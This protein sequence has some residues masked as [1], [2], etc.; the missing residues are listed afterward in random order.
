MDN[1]WGPKL[2]EAVRAG[3]VAEELIDDK[4]RRVLRLAARTGALEG[5]PAPDVPLDE[6]GPAVAH[7]V[8]VR[9]FVLARNENDTLPLSIKS[10]KRVAVI[11]ALA[12]DARVLGGGSA[13]VTPQ[14]VI[15]P[16]DGIRRALPGADVAYAIGADPRPF[17]PAAQGPDWAPFRFRISDHEF[18]VETATVRWIGDLPGGLD[19]AHVTSLELRTELTPEAAGEHVLAISGF[20]T[21]ELTVGGEVLYQGALHP[22]GTGRA[23]LLLHPREQRFS[24]TLPVGVPVPVVLRQTFEP[25]MAHS[26]STTLGHRAPGPDE[27]GLIAEAVELA[28][29]SDVAVVV[30]G[31]TEQVES[32]GFDRASLA[33]PG[34]Q[35]ELVRRVAAANPRT[36]VVVN[37]G[38]PVLLPW[39]DEAAAVLLTWFPGQEA[40]AALADVLL[41][42]AEPG[43]RLPT[44]WPRRESDCPVLDVRPSGGTLGYDED[45][46]IGYRGW[47]RSAA[48]PLFAFGHGLG[49][50]TWA[51][52]ELAV[53]GSDEAVV[54]LTNTGER[55]GR[56]VVQVYLS[57]DGD[58]VPRPERWLAGFANVQAAPGETVTVRVPLPKRAFQVWDGGWRTIPGSYTVIAAHALDDPR[59]TAKITVD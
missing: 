33:L 41:G 35:D 44:T 42:V 15:S 22:P 31:T 56:E 1:P 25:G 38:S 5:F 20:G 2:V 48:T 59:L 30:V 39:S 26:V 58:R 36:V 49:Y 13:Q 18:G 4:V 37:A 21:F 16:L 9:S 17:L 24:V 53:T 51:Y 10:L 47:L 12:T 32:E 29:R 23:D 57:G 46:F 7:E 43:G 14:H 11:G 19:V 40:G 8:A 3:K 52:A 34:R 50:T 45:I 54:T 28:A 55:T 27:Q 6:D